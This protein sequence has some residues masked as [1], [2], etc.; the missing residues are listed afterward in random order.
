MLVSQVGEQEL[1]ERL[2]PETFKEMFQFEALVQVVGTDSSQS[3]HGEFLRVR[4]IVDA[5]TKMVGFVVGVKN[6]LP[7]EQEHPQPPL[8]EGAFCDVDVLG[9]DL[10]RP[11]RDSSPGDSQRIGFF[12]RR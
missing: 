9:E 2:T 8:L 6:L 1:R 12:G 3:Y 5:Q 11:S 4:E 7:S 10:A